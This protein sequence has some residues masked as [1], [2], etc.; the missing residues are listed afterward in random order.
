MGNAVHVE[1]GGSEPDGSAKAAYPAPLFSAIYC[2]AERQVTASFTCQYT[3][4]RK[5]ASLLSSVYCCIATLLCTIQMIVVSFFLLLCPS[6]CSVPIKAKR[7]D[8]R[9]AVLFLLLYNAKLRSASRPEDETFV[10]CT[11]LSSVFITL[12][13]ITFSFTSLRSSRFIPFVQEHKLSSNNKT[14]LLSILYCLASPV[15]LRFARRN[16]VVF[17]NPKP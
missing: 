2:I 15:P 13:Y 7:K 3:K 11:Q 6:L 14:F 16:K 12:H 1:R 17:K 5:Q 9:C 4:R 8:A 10:N